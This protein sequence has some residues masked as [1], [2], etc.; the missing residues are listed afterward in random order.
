ML[1][2]ERPRG[3]DRNRQGPNYKVMLHNYRNPKPFL[4]NLFLSSP[5]DILIDFRKRGREGERDRNIDVREKH[6]L[7]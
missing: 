6:W 3:D 2:V 7:P 1:G 5:G 4:K